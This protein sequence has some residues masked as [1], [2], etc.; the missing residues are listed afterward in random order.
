[1][2]QKQFSCSSILFFLR[3]HKSTTIFG[4]C[5]RVDRDRK[6]K[7]HRF[8][9][10]RSDCNNIAHGILSCYKL[11]DVFSQFT[12]KIWKL[13]LKY[14]SY[15][16]DQRRAFSSTFICISKFT[17]LYERNLKMQALIGLKSISVYSLYTNEVTD[18]LKP[19]G[20]SVVFIHHHLKN[21]ANPFVCS[22]ALVPMIICI[23]LKLD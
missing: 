19:A 7:F 21:N 11:Q 14:F 22:I 18:C 9:P 23:I 6:C 17:Y 2:F 15:K 8:C 4:Q 3:R 5:A 1:M 13:Q 16:R 10:A 20:I 12:D